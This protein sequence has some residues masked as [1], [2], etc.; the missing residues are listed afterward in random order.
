MR[1][2]NPLTTLPA[3][4]PATAAAVTP[5]AE[6]GAVP[7]A[8]A[9]DALLAA[10]PT[11]ATGMEGGEAP[12]AQRCDAPSF[13]STMQQTAALLE[14]AVA[15]VLPP[16]E[17]AD[18]AEAGEQAPDAAAPSSL[19]GLIGL[20]GQ[21]PAAQALPPAP[22]VD[23]GT[24]PAREPFGAD[25]RL[26]QPSIS[27]GPV[28]SAA[29]LPAIAA[30]EAA[31][32]APNGEAVPLAAPAQT[33]STPRF[34][35]DGA[36][37]ALPAPPTLRLPNGDVQQWQ[38]PLLQALGDRIQLQLL[39]RSEQ[40]H[41]RLDPPQMGTVEIAL[42]HEAGQLQVSLSASH[43]EVVRQLQQISEGMRWNLA[44]QHSGEV[45]V[46]V[47]ASPAAAT[48]AGREAD[49]RQGGS[50]QRQAPDRQQEQQ[51]GRALRAEADGAAAPF[52]LG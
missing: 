48:S 18:S 50:G 21:S 9:L 31:D 45:S 17:D 42:R 4:L 22:A 12:A 3:E 1:P 32:F 30:A 16:L 34:G 28:R 23:A 26:P 51:P 6:P 13:A 8:P 39:A 11:A 40:A 15:A 24:D 2:L 41:I 47:S 25:G 36:A 7:F 43:G 37:P 52:A 14:S 19:L 44:Q 10:L 5:S 33:A 20:I 49:A 46:Q 38:S 35:I 27:A 29:A